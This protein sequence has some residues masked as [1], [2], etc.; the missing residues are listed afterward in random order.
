MKQLAAPAGLPA[1]LLRGRPAVG[2]DVRVEDRL[3][4][5]LGAL[6]PV[7]ATP[8][9]ATSR[10]IQYWML[11]GMVREA[12]A[13]VVDRGL[14]YDFTYMADR[15]IGWERPKTLGHAHS[16]PAA[17]V[18]GFGEVCEVLEGVAGF[19]FQDILP[20]PRAT[21][22]ALVTVKPGERVIMPPFL[23]HATINLEG[24]PLVFSD[25]ISRA[26][27]PDYRTLAAAHG[28]AWYI[29]IAGEARRNPGYVE[30]PPLLRFST[31]EWG[32]PSGDVPLYSEYV[33]NPKAF[34]WL[35]RPDLFPARYPALWE[36][37]REVVARLDAA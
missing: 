2:P 11:N 24:D 12:D 21:F 10:R 30:A 17:G 35:C 25:V 20:G 28:M 19:L 27:R 9:L 13:D 32:G 14:S 16:R 18:L 23:Q 26:A 5:A 36:R 4:R 15:P 8:V 33:A 7:A 31:R 34:D 29:D 1:G 3:S 37:L 6:A 22:A